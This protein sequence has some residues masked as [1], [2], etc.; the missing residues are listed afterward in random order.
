MGFAL[1]NV[2]VMIPL[3]FTHVQADAV[4]QALRLGVVL[5]IPTPIGPMSSPDFQVQFW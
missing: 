5:L 1:Q 3:T 4:S 2:H